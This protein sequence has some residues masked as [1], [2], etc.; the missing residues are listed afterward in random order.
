MRLIK[1]NV[2]RI[3]ESEVKAAKLK[4]AGFQDLAESKE[5][6]EEVGAVVI[7]DMNVTELK[8]M[9]KEKG[10]EGYSSLTKEE[11]LEAIKDV[12]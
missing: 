10:L 4:N 6:K 9:A 12:V 7:A 5:Q 2:E 11:L 1:G 8:A 3:V